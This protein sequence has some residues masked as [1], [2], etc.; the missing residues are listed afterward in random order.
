M[1]ELVECRLYIR[2]R[3]IDYR[4]QDAKAVMGVLDTSY[5][6][7]N[8][9]RAQ[10][11]SCEWRIFK[12]KSA[13]LKFLKAA[14]QTKNKTTLALPSSLPPH[15]HPHLSPSQ[16]PQLLQSSANAKLASP[17]SVHNPTHLS[18]HLY[19]SLYQIRYALPSRPPNREPNCSGSCSRETTLETDREPI[20]S[21]KPNCSFETD[22]EGTRE[23]GREPC[24]IVS[25]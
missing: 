4:V 16:H 7:P 1:N 10:L 20:C 12:S 24:T 15:P 17:F 6:S 2:L 21:L 5:T 3:S 13:R 8:I 25:V 9:F 19:P 22:R 11:P 18:I 23:T 14:V